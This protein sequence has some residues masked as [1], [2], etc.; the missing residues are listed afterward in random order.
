MLSY[1]TL[2]FIK[3][4]YGESNYE[5]SCGTYGSDFSEWGKI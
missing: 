3:D 5:S 1:N 2:G 4:K